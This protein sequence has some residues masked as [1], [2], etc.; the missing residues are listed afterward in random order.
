[1]LLQGAPPNPAIR[2]LQSLVDTTNARIAA[3]W[4]RVHSRFCYSCDFTASTTFHPS[5]VTRHF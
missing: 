3:L 5:P 1:M 2:R 4:N